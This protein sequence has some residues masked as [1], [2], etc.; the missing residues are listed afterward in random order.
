[1]VE[2]TTHNRAVAGSIPAS[3][4]TSPI[5]AVVRS[6]LIPAGSRVLVAVSGGP[7][8]TALLLALR[9]LNYEVVAAHFDHAL[10][11]GS[12]QDALHVADLCARVQ[13]GLI[14]ER[15]SGRL[16]TGSLQ[17]V[18]R[19]AR[20]EFL[21][22]A[23]IEAACDLIATAH[24][25][26][27]LVETIV[28]NLLRG[29][30]VRGLRGIPPRHGLVVRPFLRTDRPSITGYLA[31]RGETARQDPS[32]RDLRFLRARVRHLLLPGMPRL[33]P[34]IWSLAR[35]AARADNRLASAPGG[36]EPAVRRACLRQLFVDAGGAD[37]GLTRAHLAEM[38]RLLMAR[39][40]GAQLALPGRLTF[41]VLP[42]GEPLI[43]RDNDL[44][45]PVHYRLH[46][47]QCPGCDDPDAVHL[48]QGVLTLATRTPGLRL[49]PA[50]GRGTRKLQDLLVDAKVP[51]H[52]RDTYP[53][54]FLDG[55]LAWV[56][57]IAVDVAKMCPKSLPGRH[58]WV[59]RGSTSPMVRSG[60]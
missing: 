5:E 1:M 60:H 21:E 53:L 29:T 44:P 10:R 38:D 47:R 58:V 54:V 57:G 6:E 4:T 37:P 33:G 39:R 46:E 2:H 23:R 31:Q 55:E 42:S 3:A 28:M 27:D 56:P 51:R 30:G 24:T 13:V 16:R 43:D 35:A 41:R 26:D 9:N 19:E 59:G 32:N 25:A 12:E 17:A 40:T 18:A 49:R 8:S 22:R 15:R 7:D 20:Y 11:P 34:K 36:A 52:E 14:T 48:H 50:G 45:P